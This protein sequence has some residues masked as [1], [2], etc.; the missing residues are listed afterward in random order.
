MR[1]YYIENLKKEILNG[2]ENINEE[3]IYD[4]GLILSK[5]KNKNIF[6][7]GVGKSENFAKHMAD[8][9]KSVAYNSFLLNHT[10][11]LHGDL[12][13]VKANDIVFIISKSGKS[14][15]LIKPVEYIRKKNALVIGLFCSKDN[16]LHSLCHKTIILPRQKE[17]DPN[18]D[19]VPTTSIIIY[20]IFLSLLIRHLFDIDNINLEKYGMNHPAGYIGQVILTKVEDCLIP[21]DKTPIIRF[22]DLQKI[23]IYH[24]ME[25]IDKMKVG[26]VCFVDDDFKLVGILTNGMII[27]HLV[28]SHTLVQPLDQPMVKSN[29]KINIYN[30]IEYNPIIIKDKLQTRIYDLNLGL[31]HIYFPVIEKGKLIGLF[32]NIMAK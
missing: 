10:D 27:Q 13:C 23:N 6:C 12:G 19:L 16:M 30:I 28:K 3:K 1:N 9:L 17:M 26:I 15:E 18:F 22:S 31:K 14:Q 5:N 2:I 4:L 8:M 7:M 21:L 32:Y 11:C 25:K 20:N 29:N 24:I